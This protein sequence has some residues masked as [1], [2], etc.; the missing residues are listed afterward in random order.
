MGNE[1]SSH[2]TSSATVHLLD[3][4]K[5]HPIQSWRFCDCFRITIGR[6]PENHVCIVDPQVSRLHTEFTFADGQWKLTSHGRNGTRIRGESVSDVL[7]TDAVLFQLGANGP[8]L[9]FITR[10]EAIAHGATIDP[11]TD[12]QFGL[13]FMVVDEEKTQSEVQRIAD[14]E[15]FKLLQQQARELKQRRKLE[16]TE[17][18]EE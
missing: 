11:A 4:A 3:S 15:S 7:V 5:G 14:A 16:E 2:S 1:S 9:K 6:L 10:Q 18:A 8:L 17:S 13:D 12:D